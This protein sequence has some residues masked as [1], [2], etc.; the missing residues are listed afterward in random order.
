MNQDLK[1]GLL[2][3][4]THVLTLGKKIGCILFDDKEYLPG[5]LLEKIV[6]KSLKSVG[7]NTV[8]G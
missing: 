2:V 7:N 1:N 4:K 6:R 8:A 3:P 5:A